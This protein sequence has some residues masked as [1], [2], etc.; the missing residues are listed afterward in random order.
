MMPPMMPPGSMGAPPPGS[1]GQGGPMR[2]PPPAGEMIRPPGGEGGNKAQVL[3]RLRA[4]L[5]V[6][7]QIA[8]KNG[9]PFEEVVAGVESPKATQPGP[10]APP[11]PTRPPPGM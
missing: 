5:R 4:M 2:P 7:Q 10:T 1:M 9:I 3:E 6:V 11:P 8:D